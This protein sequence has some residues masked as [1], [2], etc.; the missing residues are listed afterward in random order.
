MQPE[1][2]SDK[3]QVTK[4]EKGIYVC[5]L[6]WRDKQQCNDCFV[7]HNAAPQISGR[8]WTLLK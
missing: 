6:D 5:V 4:H 7:D 1:Q 2:R 8:K 3:V